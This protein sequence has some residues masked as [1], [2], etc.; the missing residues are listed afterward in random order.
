MLQLKSIT[1]QNEEGEEI[2]V[3]VPKGFQLQISASSETDAN[4][5]VGGLLAKGY[6]GVRSL[7][8]D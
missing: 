5:A 1:F 7:F 3:E 2:I 8:P 6:S 4:F